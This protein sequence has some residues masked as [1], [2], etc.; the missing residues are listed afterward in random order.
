[1]AAQGV[2]HFRPTL[3]ETLGQFATEH[4]D[5]AVEVAHRAGDR[6]SQIGRVA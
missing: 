5:D 1:M 3:A 6:A 2:A 4:L